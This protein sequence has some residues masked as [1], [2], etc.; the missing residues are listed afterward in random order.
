MPINYQGMQFYKQLNPY[1]PQ[2]GGTN[3]GVDFSKKYNDLN[4]RLSKFNQKLDQKTHETIVGKINY[5]NE[6]NK[7]LNDTI[8]NI[9]KYSALVQNKGIPVFERNIS[10]KKINEL[11]KEYEETFAKSVK[12]IVSIS[13]AFGKMQYLIEEQE[14]KEAKPFYYTIGNN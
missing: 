8:N 14:L 1:I 7:Q 12:K 3:E 10:E 5:I 13:T 6:L 11:L 9:N 2:S 4:L